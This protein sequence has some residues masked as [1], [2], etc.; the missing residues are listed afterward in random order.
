[1]IFQ[2]SRDIDTGIWGDRMTVIFTEDV[3]ATINARFKKYKLN[4]RHEGKSS[5]ALFYNLIETPN[6]KEAGW[7]VFEI[8]E[9]ESGL[10][11]HECSH[12]TNS[13]LKYKG[14]VFSEDS[15]EA[16]TYTM[17]YLIKQVEAVYKKA[18]VKFKSRKK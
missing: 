11:A 9:M 5:A 17:Q 8:G 13:L 6:A 7:L 10:I 15:E 16:Y 1:M 12:A 14:L 2:F 18:L 3:H 4:E